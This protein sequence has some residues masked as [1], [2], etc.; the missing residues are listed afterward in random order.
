MKPE[1]QLDDVRATFSDWCRRGRAEGMER[2]HA[3]AARVAF[4]RLD[5]AEDGRFLDVGCGNG[6]AVRWAA[7]A[8]PRGL[9]V[10]VDLSSDM[11][12]H[13]A[14]L[15]DGLDNV[16]FLAGNVTDLSLTELSVDGA[17]FDAVFSM[18][19]LYYVPRLDD[20]LR[21]IA[22]LL[23]PGGRFASTVNF[24][25]ENDASASWPADV[26]VDMNRLD[27]AGWKR[28]FENAGFREV[29]QD[30]IRLKP[31]ETDDAWKVSE[32]SLWTMGCRP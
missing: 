32:G 30:R 21:Y 16:R 13:A 2:D 5:L 4:E 11:I 8:A 23:R 19:A 27:A 9:A 25:E 31:A 12:E 28:A 14:T 26:G 22:N 6:Y 24:Y 20:T 7:H 1:R 15:V 17:P 10:G 29:E 3:P 18:E